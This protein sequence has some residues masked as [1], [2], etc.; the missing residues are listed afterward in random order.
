[1]D[2]VHDARVGGNRQRLRCFR[3]VC[4]I[5]DRKKSGAVACAAGDNSE[6]RLLTELPREGTTRRGHT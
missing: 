6:R 3:A 2:I 1:M 5:C 4:L